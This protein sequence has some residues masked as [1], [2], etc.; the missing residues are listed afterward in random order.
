MS[1]DLGAAPSTKDKKDD[2]R[3]RLYDPATRDKS[4]DGNWAQYLVDL[5]DARGTFDFCG[6]MMFQLVLSD[7]LRGR[8]E[9]VAGGREGSQPIVFDAS[10]TRMNGTP[11][12]VQSADADSVAIFHGREVRDVKGATGGMGM[13]LHLSD[14]H[15]DPQGW[16]HQE[17]DDYNG[18]GH[19]SGRPWRN[20]QRW[21]SEGVQGFQEAFGAP[22]YGLHH[23]FYLHL[24]R[25][26]NFWLSAEDGCE[27]FAS[28]GSKKGALRSFFSQ[29]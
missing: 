12:Y 15:E 24:D 1:S 29:F 5:H 26:N 19:D 3:T 9:A 6:G 23:R 16:S 25:Q 28:N 21:T 2:L 4:Y 10:T 27:G 20:M 17:V 14:C 22:A 7:K 18:W 13:V 8:L 11:G